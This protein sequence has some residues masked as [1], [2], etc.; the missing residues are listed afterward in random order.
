MP[1]INETKI[2]YG[3]KGVQDMAKLLRELKLH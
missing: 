3:V 1:L 2:T